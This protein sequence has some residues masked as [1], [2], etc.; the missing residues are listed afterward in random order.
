M[1]KRYI[2]K[3]ALWGNQLEKIDC[4]S[5]IFQFS[6]WE[7]INFAKEIVAGDKNQNV[8]SLSWLNQVKQRS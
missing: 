5:T 2:T 8:G 7:N 6:I 3:R 4:I 1:P